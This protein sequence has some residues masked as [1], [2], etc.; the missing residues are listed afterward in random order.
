MKMQECRKSGIYN[1]GFMDPNVIHEESVCQYPNRTENNI[2]M[3][4]KGQHDRTF[5]LFPYNFDF[6]WILLVIEID[7]SR[8][9]VW[10]SLKKPL[11]LYQ[12]LVHIMQRA[13]SRFL[14][15]Q[16]GVTSTPTELEFNHNKPCLRQ[17]QGT[18]LCGYYVCEHMH[19]F[20]QRYQEGDTRKLR[21]LEYEREPHRTRKNQGN[22]RSTLWIP[23]G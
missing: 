13:W 2:L 17:N 7:R 5:I 8:V 6:H 12:N 4:L 20:F 10:D 18:N 21:N 15:M 22:S 23:V 14:K 16:L 1:V 19:F 9:N 3:S 11:E